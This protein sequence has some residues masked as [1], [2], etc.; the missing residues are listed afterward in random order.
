M[1]FFSADPTVLIL[2][3]AL[4]IL[5]LGLGGNATIF[6][7]IVLSGLPVDTAGLGTGIYGLF[8]DLAAPFGVAIFVPMF[9]N[10]ITTLLEHS[11][12]EITAAS[13]AV[14]SI[15]M[16]SV[17]ELCCVGIG[18]IIVQLLPRIHNKSYVKGD[19]K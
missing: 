6:M 8:R 16:L 18:I 2:A 17:I 1:L 13:A 15:R 14:N 7:K 10:R 11:H 4:G 3:A 19:S 5:G 12:S 9:T